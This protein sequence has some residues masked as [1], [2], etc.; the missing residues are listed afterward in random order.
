MISETDGGQD[1][2]TLVWRV[3]RKQISLACM[4]VRQATLFLRLL[5]VEILFELSFCPRLSAR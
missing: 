4:L 3:I 2:P 1:Q 5:P